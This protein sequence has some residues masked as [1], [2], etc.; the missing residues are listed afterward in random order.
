MYNSPVTNYGAWQGITVLQLTHLY[1]QTQW[2]SPLREGIL[3]ISLCSLS[4]FQITELEKMC[5]PMILVVVVPRYAKFHTVPH[6]HCVLH[7]H[8][9][10]IPRTIIR[11]LN[12]KT[13][14]E[15]AFL[16]N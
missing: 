13:N 11:Y 15:S 7:T 9:V 8:E 2:S 6:A 4:L 10:V 1:R 12:I 16:T 3:T 14:I 5:W